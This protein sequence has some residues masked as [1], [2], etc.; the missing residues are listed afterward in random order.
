M[1][2]NSSFENQLR[3]HAGRLRLARAGRQLRQ[4]LAAI[5]PE[6]H[7]SIGDLPPCERQNAAKRY[8]TLHRA[9]KTFTFASERLIDCSPLVTEL[10]VTNAEI[11]TADPLID[12]LAAAMETECEVPA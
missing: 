7:D 6:V 10:V 8:D 1:V 11:I 12:P 2:S 9:V 5:A 4:L 3:D